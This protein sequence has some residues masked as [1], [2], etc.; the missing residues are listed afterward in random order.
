MLIDFIKKLYNYRALIWNMALREIRLRYAGTLAGFM[1]SVINPVMMIFVFWLVFSVL[2]KSQP[3]GNVPFVITFVCGL[4]PWTT[5]NESVMA[6]SNSIIGNSHLIKK[7][8][9]PSE[10]LPIVSLVASCISHA[11]MLVI[12]FTLLLA[13]RMPFSIYNLQVIYYMAALS[14]FSIGLGWLCSAINVFYRDTSQTLG[15]IFNMWFW[16]TPVVWDMNI[17]PPKYHYL[18]KLNPFFYIVNGYKSSFF[19]NLP[20]WHDYALGIYFWGF[21]L[22]TLLAGAFVFRRLKPEFAEVL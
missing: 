18:V 16:L 10:I 17:V 22:F 19:N 2:F 21:C 7:T 4:I 3:V 13:Y 12:L 11:I 8:I 6:S 20:L 5:F 15:V 1:W 9:F 14:L